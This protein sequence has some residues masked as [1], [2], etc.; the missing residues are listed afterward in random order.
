MTSVT[1][2]I[3]PFNWL[4]RR[5][6]SDDFYSFWRF[7]GAQLD[8]PTQNRRRTDVKRRT[9]S[10]E[11]RLFAAFGSNKSQFPP[12]THRFASLVGTKL[13]TAVSPKMRNA[14]LKWEVEAEKRDLQTPHLSRASEKLQKHFGSDFLSED[15]RNNQRRTRLGSEELSHFA[16]LVSK[17]RGRA[18]TA[19]R[20]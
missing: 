10:W 6:L 14:A 12:K 2:P 11:T 9:N 13:Q 16:A 19:A 1:Q 18:A 15:K 7:F 5:S 20:T 3:N 17:S 4:Q 8:Q